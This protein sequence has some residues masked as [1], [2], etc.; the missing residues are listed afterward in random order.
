MHYL[1]LQVV[2]QQFGD[3]VCGFGILSTLMP[4][5]VSLHS[6]G[7]DAVNVVYI[8]FH[9]LDHSLVKIIISTQ[10]MPVSQERNTTKKHDYEKETSSRRENTSVRRNHT[11]ACP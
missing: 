9:S 4:A 5:Q 11:I 10:G 8:L 1:V 6:A 2:Q 7:I 3:P